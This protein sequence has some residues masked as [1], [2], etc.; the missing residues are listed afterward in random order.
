MDKQTQTKPTMELEPPL[1]DVPKTQPETGIVKKG[2]GLLTAIIISVVM[3]VASVAVY[4]HF[5]APKIVALDIKGFLAEKRDLYVQGKLTE[6]DFKKSIDNLEAV[7][8]SIPSNHMVLAGD[9]VLRNV[10]VLKVEGGKASK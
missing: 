9:A 10:E 8:N 2:V 3:S 4:H 7:A 5:Y 1:P 6:A